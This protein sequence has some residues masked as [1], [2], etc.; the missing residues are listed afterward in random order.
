M[1]FTYKGEEREINH[2]KRIEI[3]FKKYKN[4]IIK[5]QLI[6]IMK[7]DFKAIDN[8]II[9]I[10]NNIYQNHKPNLKLFNLL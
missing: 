10:K 5:L 3:I 9:K 8:Q 2:R 4:R 6:I 1:L 7:K